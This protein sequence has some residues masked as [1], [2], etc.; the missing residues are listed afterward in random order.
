MKNTLATGAYQLTA[1]LLGFVTPRLMMAYYGSEINGLV[2]SITEF[3]G[4]FKLVEAG[5]AA[6]A[7]YGLYK[8]LSDHDRP[9]W[10][11]PARWS[12]LHYPVTGCC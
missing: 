11:Y 6:A 7:I 12:S 3:M 2:A 9:S 1:M 4:Y 5:L 8:P 10:A